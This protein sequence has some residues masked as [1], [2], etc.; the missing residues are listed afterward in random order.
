MKTVGVTDYTNQTPSKQLTEKN[1]EVQDPSKRKTSSPMGN[2]HS[3]WSQHIV[4]RHHN[5][6]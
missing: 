5:L 2:D 6:R 3:P 1:V 4:W